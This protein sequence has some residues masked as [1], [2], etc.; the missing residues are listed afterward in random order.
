M[1]CKICPTW[2][3][4][5]RVRLE[6]VARAAG[7]SPKTVSRVLNDEI[8]VRDSTRAR[9]RAVMLELNYRPHL[10]ARSLASNQSF[11]VA[12]LYD[13]PSSSY[14]TEVQDGVLEAC[15]QHQYSMLVRPLHA[16]AEDFVER[17][18]TLISAH[19]PD[20]L[21][22]TPP[23]SD[24]PGL[25]ARLKELG[26]IYSCV[27]PKH[28][29]GM[30]GVFMD[31]QKAACEIVNHLIALGHQRIAHIIGHTVHGASGWRLAGYR[32]A[33]V[34]AGLPWIPELVVQGDFS[35]ASGVE[36]ARKL[37]AMDAPPTA[38]FAGNDDMA[39]GVIWTASEH[40]LSVPE[41]LSVCGFDDTPISRQVWPT[42]TT[43][44]QPARDMGRIACLQ[45][46][47][48]LRGF[49]PGRMV[50]V[51][52]SLRMRE[53]TA[54]TRKAAQIAG[55]DQGNGKNAAPL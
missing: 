26:V 25:L 23:I 35:F 32:Q 1:W 30:I 12:T 51:P 27:A 4:D 8:N 48:V 34:E 40:G 42:L 14:L 24:H 3:S 55:H 17:V 5:M 15:D 2:K 54:P 18:D 6:D 36:A 47:D 29:A 39:S 53:S 21:V 19:R 44:H 49:G 28:R 16:E 33:L 37:F 10:S 38:V 20:G 11:M 41:D 7:V 13:N 31:E 43:I 46:L 45:L 9:V 50:Q 52:Y 22:L